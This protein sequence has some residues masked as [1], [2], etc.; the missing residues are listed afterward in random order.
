MN[1]FNEDLLGKLEEVQVIWARCENIRPGDKPRRPER[2]AIK[3]IENHWIPHLSAVVSGSFA[4]SERKIPL[5]AL[6]SMA[7]GV[8][9]MLMLARGN[10]CSSK[11]E[12]LKWLSDEHIE[13]RE[14]INLFRE[15]F[16][17]SDDLAITL[18]ARQAST[19]GRF[20]LGL[21]RKVKR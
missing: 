16:E 7:S 18:S 3:D 15:D 1:H 5:S 6:I 4:T 8:A 21:L 10:I 20:Y 11:R 12:L 19:L 9:Q 13:I 17:K 2:L 14:M